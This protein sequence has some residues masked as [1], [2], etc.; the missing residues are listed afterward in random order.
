MES[1]MVERGKLFAAYMIKHQCTIRQVAKAFNASKTTVHK[2]VSE[3]LE[4]NDPM[5]YKQVKA[6]LVKNKAERH[7]RG[8]LATKKKFLEQKIV[9]A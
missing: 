1:Y 8:G 2:D 4:Q 9:K 3:R 6:L 5:L 7:M